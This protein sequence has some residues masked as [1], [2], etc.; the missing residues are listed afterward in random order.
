[1]EANE[2]PP[3]DLSREDDQ[4]P[5]IKKSVVY[6][7]D[8]L[9]S[10][11]TIVDQFNHFSNWNRLKRVIARILRLVT[12][13][14]N[15]KQPRP[16][17]VEETEKAEICI[18]RLVQQAAFENEIT[19]LKNINQE[20]F[21][22]T[23]SLTK[24]KKCKL[25]KASSLYKLDPFID[26]QDL[27]RV[28]G[29]LKNADDFNENLKHPIIL[30][31]KG[32][33]T[34]LIIRHA[35]EKM[36]H[37][38]RGM[39]LNQLREKFWIINA[40]T[41]VRSLISKCVK[42]RRYRGTSLDQKMADLP[43]CRVAQEPPFTYCGVDLFGPFTIKE[44]RKELKRYGVIFTCLSSRAVHIETTT[45][46]ETDTFLN[47][48][49]RFVAR[50][51]PIREVYSDQGTNLVGADTELK[52][53]LKEL[54]QPRLQ[55][56]VL[57][58]FNADIIWKRNPPSASHMGGAWE[59]QI[60]TIRSILKSLMHEF[61]HAINDESLRTLLTE[62]ESIVN[63]RPLTFPSSD[64]QD[65][66]PLTPNHILTMKSKV[67]LPPPGVFQKEDIY[68]K[69]RW[70]RVQYLT[71]IFWTR[72]KREYIQNLQ[73]RM[74]WNEVKRNLQVGDIVLIKQENTPRNAW[75]LAR[76][77]QVKSDH[78]GLVRSAKV[79]TA[80]TILDRPIS[81]LILLQANG[82]EQE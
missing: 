17:K 18:L 53:A 8:V 35:H 43:K 79:K 65:L 49:R 48:L 41:A 2:E 20:T 24:T 81:K 4:D 25:K 11:P 75:P 69:K 44:G 33:V 9:E 59:R 31:K 3:V 64:P 66:D 70:R 50:R 51:G 13:Q 36:A 19:T 38:G 27:I 73:P 47:A 57:T 54:D 1:M 45:S 63:S 55:E 14:E 77:L 71:N 5:E 22:D 58:K 34:N 6:S 23:R 80:A 26:H 12:T 82:Q 16:I 37:A 74:K 62:V 46:L 60:R 39:T 7:T 32:N 76:I 56:Q 67:V 10:K 30:P 52:Q 28:G 68:L 78:H 15:S 40:N 42:C 21:Q 29:R 61:G 72:W